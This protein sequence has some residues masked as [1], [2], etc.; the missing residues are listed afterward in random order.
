MALFNK[1]NLEKHKPNKY[2]ITDDD[3][4]GSLKGYPVGIVVRMMEEQE[5]QGNK[6]DV[7]VFQINSYS[8]ADIGGFD[9]SESVDGEAFWDKS[10]PTHNE[11]HPEKYFKFFF[12]KYPEY[13]KYN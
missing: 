8:A 3:M 2:G 12:K 13:E 10:I 9:W 7:E 6:P 1:K 5:R 11:P 4:I